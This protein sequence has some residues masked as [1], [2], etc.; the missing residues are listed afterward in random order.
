MVSVR[1]VENGLHI[2]VRRPKG[3]ERARGGRVRVGE[4][5]AC[6]GDVRVHV[7]AAAHPRGWLDRYELGGRAS[8]RLVA[9]RWEDVSASFT[10]RGAVEMLAH[11]GPRDPR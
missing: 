2:R 7:G 9:E 6:K 1:H 8:D 4:V 5:A 11:L 3:T 10:K